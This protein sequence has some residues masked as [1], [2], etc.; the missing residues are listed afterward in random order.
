MLHEAHLLAAHHQKDHVAQRIGVHALRLDVGGAAV[1][2]VDDE[3]FQLLVVVADDEQQLVV[4]RAVEQVGDHTRRDV[5]RDERIERQHPAVRCRLARADSEADHGQSRQHDEPVG[6]QDA[7]RE[8]DPGELLQQHAHDVRAPRGRLL[9][10]DDTLPDA[11]HH[12]A[13]DAR[14]QQVVRE[15]QPPAQQQRR[16][17]RLDRLGIRVDQPREH[18]H[19]A[20]RIERRQHRA[21]AETAA[22]DQHGDQHQRNVEHVTERTDLDRRE[23]VMQHDTHAVDPARHEL[24]GIDE[25]HEPR[26]HDRAA[27]ENQKPRAPPRPRA[28]RFEQSLCVHTL[29]HLKCKDTKFSG[30]AGYGGGFFAPGFH[31]RIF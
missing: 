23:D 1:E 21:R 29:I 13:D 10:H 16:V 12:G 20:R 19:K 8:L 30:N 24:V 22:E 6:Q 5:D 17:Q 28:H 7:R 3:P 11:D 26:A 2:V 14:Q 4:R 9:S 25:E 15:V 31:I 27:E 18:V